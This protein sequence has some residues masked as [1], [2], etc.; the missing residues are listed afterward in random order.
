MYFPAEYFCTCMIMNAAIAICRLPSTRL[1]C[2][3]HVDP[4]PILYDT[5]TLKR[6]SAC[7]IAIKCYTLHGLAPSSSTTPPQ[8]SLSFS[9]APFNC[10]TL[11]TSS[12]YS[13]NFL[14]PY[15]FQSIVAI[16]MRSTYCNSTLLTAFFVITSTTKTRTAKYSALS[17]NWWMP[18]PQSFCC[19]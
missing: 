6:D 1:Q 8:P 17:L 2:T 7:T 10:N 13:T 11:H 5:C 9:F 15:L 19:H 12:L 3:S 16:G 4:L 14:L 18:L